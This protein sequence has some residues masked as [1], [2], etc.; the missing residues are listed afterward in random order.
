VN[1]LAGF[2]AR[3]RLAAVLGAVAIA[4]SGIFYRWSAVSP[5]TGVF[6]RS[7]YGLPILLLVAGTEQR[8]LGPMTRRAVGLSAVAGLFFAA[9][10]TAYHYAV[11]AIGAGLATVLANLQVVIVAGV[12]WLAFGER[13]RREVLV[14]IPVMLAGVVLIS[15]V[16]GSGAYG[17]DPRA[18][19]ALGLVAAT[20]YAGY[21]LVIRGASPDRRPAGPVAVA[22]AITGLCAL[23][24]GLAIGDLDLVPSLPSHVYLLAL[25]ILSQSVGYLAIQAS[26]PRLP[27][28]IASLLL[29]VQPLTTM[30]L[31]T[32][33]LGELP[34]P[35]QV[36]GVLLVIGGLAL[37]TG[38]LGRVRGA[39]LPSRGPGAA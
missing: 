34:S 8:R 20:A 14:A 27:A 17:T 12:A 22:T 21:L 35:V 24:F 11:D 5:V 2:E 38:S 37:A 31:G 39:V 19:V 6:W 23:A 15:G 33:L 36:F 32:L 30:L 25:G 4:F 10:L 16:V 7:V 28:V 18:G 3:P 1:P 13:P 29:F 26:L 9:D